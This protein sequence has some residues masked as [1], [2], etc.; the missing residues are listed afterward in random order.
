[1]ILWSNSLILHN[2]IP[3]PTFQISTSPSHEEKP[4]PRRL[5]RHRQRPPQR[6]HAWRCRGRAGRLWFCRNQRG[7]RRP[8][9]LQGWD[10]FTLSFC[11]LKKNMD[12]FLE[13]L[14][15]LYE[16][17]SF[18]AWFLSVFKIF[19]DPLLH[20]CTCW[21][22]KRHHQMSQLWRRHGTTMQVTCW[23]EG[24]EAGQWRCRDQP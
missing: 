17:A 1:M 4:Q 22:S 21:T 3:F 8:W 16:E 9:R 11:F 12:A 14:E 18:L 23:S 15:F 6:H 24:R 20:S 5:G 19:Q 10:C 13:A 7:G 2:F